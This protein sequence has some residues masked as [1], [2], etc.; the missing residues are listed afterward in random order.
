MRSIVVAGIAMGV[1]SLIADPLWFVNYPKMLLGY[2]DEGNVS[3]C[4]ECSSV[5]IWM[6]RW[7]FNSSLKQAALIA[8]AL[9]VV[10][11]ILFWL[12]RRS[13]LRSPEL[14]VTSA[15]LITLLAS[16]YLYNYDFILLLV[17]FAVLVNSSGIA[18]K[19]VAVL[20]YLVPSLAIIL[21]SRNGNI[22]LNVVT[23]LIAFVVYLHARSQVD[24]PAR[25]TYNTNN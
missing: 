18:P 6:S 22:T 2:Q 12:I 15:L 7:L 9:L 20:S 23:I 16:P 17:P 21:Y 25:T 10:L 14:L 5:P 19:I 11:L 24:V 13:L 4:S 1:V 3:S 8:I